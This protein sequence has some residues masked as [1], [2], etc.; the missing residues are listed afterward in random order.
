M[1]IWCAKWGLTGD[2]LDTT[3]AR[4]TDIHHI[5]CGRSQ[6]TRLEPEHLV[7]S[8]V[9]STNI[10]PTQSCCEEREVGLTFGRD[11]SVTRPNGPAI[12]L[13][14]A[15]VFAPL[16]FEIKPRGREK[17]RVTGVCDV[18]G[19]AERAGLRVTKTY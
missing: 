12:E 10:R 1:M 17:Q 13:S 18:L 6:R 7:Y 5:C 9:L 4:M 2:D 8:L 15:G 11:T 14:S 19:R 16:N 3:N